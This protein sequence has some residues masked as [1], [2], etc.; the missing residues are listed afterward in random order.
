MFRKKDV[1]EMLDWFDLSKYADVKQHAPD[2]QV[3]VAA[4][5]MPCDQ[6]WSP[7]QVQKF[8]A[9]MDAGMLP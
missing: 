4:G 1:D 5:D 8:K 2:I 3:R 9:W 6:A 7:A